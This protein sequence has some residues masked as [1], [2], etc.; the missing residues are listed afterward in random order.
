MKRRS[1]FLIIFFYILYFL[2]QT[3]D[4]IAE[5]ALTTILLKEAIQNINSTFKQVNSVGTVTNPCLSSQLII[6]KKIALVREFSFKGVKEKCFDFIKKNGELGKWGEVIENT[7]NELSAEEKNRTFLSNNIPDMEFICPKFKDFSEYLKIKF[8]VW[9]FASISFD[10][11]SCN[12]FI[13]D[14]PGEQ[15]SLKAQ[16]LLQLESFRSLRKERGRHCDVNNIK[17]PENNLACGVDILYEILKGKDSLYYDGKSTG[18]LFWKGSYWAKIRLKAKNIK[19]LEEKKQDLIDSVEI[20][21]D[22][23][24]LKELVMKFPTCR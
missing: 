22:K 18:E 14:G 7:I 24:H 8:Y 15:K 23:T 16:G 10:E 3:N 12:E 21:D 5:N 2:G 19:K 1:S 13:K 6:H 20:D 9:V 17:L 11:S 4:A